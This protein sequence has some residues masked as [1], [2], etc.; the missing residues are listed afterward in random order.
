[1]AHFRPRVWFTRFSP[2]LVVKHV[3]AV[4]LSVVVVVAVLAV[5]ANAIPFA[6][7]LLK[8][9]A[10]LVTSLARL[11]VRNLARRNSLEA[12]EQAGEK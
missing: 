1:L 8:I 2:S 12:V 3:D 7:H 6:Q 11:H 4:E 5:A 10:H 9:G